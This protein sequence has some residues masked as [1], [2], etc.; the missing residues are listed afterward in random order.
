MSDCSIS[1]LF[2]MIVFIFILALENWNEE[3]TEP[4][5]WHS[6]GHRKD[7]SRRL[8]ALSTLCF[9]HCFDDAGWMSGRTSN[10]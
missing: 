9:L 7:E 4:Y 2:L 3:S 5:V 10:P 1:Y 6:G 8:V